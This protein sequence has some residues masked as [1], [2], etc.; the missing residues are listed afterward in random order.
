MFRLYYCAISSLV[1]T[2]ALLTQQHL[3]AFISRWNFASC[4]ILIFSG[5]NTTHKKRMLHNDCHFIPIL[6]A[7]LLFNEEFNTK[8]NS[9]VI[10][11]RV[12]TYSQ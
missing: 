4:Y 9:F 7:W 12:I 2:L 6:A 3:G 10:A 1:L 11:F 8:S 5:V